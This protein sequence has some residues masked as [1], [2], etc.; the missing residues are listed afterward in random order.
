MLGPSP[1]VHPPPVAAGPSQLPAVKGSRLS[2]LDALRGLAALSVFLGH[3]FGMM[4]PSSKLLLTIQNTPLH[5]FY[6]GNAAVLLFFVLSGFVLN[7]RYADG[8]S[9]PSGWVGSFIIRRVF[10]IY[11]AFL[12]SMGLAV[13][14]RTCLFRPEWTNGFS[15]WFSSLWRAPLLW[16]E[17]ARCSTLVAPGIQTRFINP[18]DWSL[19]Y[20]MRISFFFPIIILVVNPKRRPRWDLVLIIA[21]YVLSLVLTPF[22]SSFQY[23]PQF[24]LGA[25]CAKY[26]GRIQPK[27][28][29]FSSS[30]KVLWLMIALFLY[31]ASAMTEPLRLHDWRLTFLIAQMVGLG[32][33]VII[34]VSA[35]SGRISSL[36]RARVCQF[37]GCT[38]Y[39]FYLT[40]FL[41]L[42]VVAPPCYLATGS[43]LIAWLVT[44]AVAYLVSYLLFRFVEVPGMQLG[45]WAS[46]VFA[47]RWDAGR[48]G[49]KVNSSASASRDIASPQK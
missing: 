2:Q 6:D 17:V 18:P 25:V 21:V 31:G 46:D 15:D 23:I 27:L 4:S 47:R 7:L 36:L 26:F 38:S 42:F 5:F 30:A 34:L 44:L 19:V 22:A 37:V 33:A 20:E 29:A 41:F 12:A 32:S 35:S 10:R 48:K 40:H 49:A 24:A 11:P 1:L 43:Y 39:S 9:H 28:A 45:S 8:R 14:F 16:G 3:A 13:L